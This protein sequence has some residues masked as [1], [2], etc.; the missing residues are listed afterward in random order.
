MDESGNIIGEAKAVSDI[1]IETTNENN[2]SDEDIHSFQKS[3]TA[4]LE[5]TNLNEYWINKLIKKK[6]R[7]KKNFNNK[8]NKFI[9]KENYHG[10]N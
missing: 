7:R 9:N 4:T 5:V 6:N 2:N 1:V 3:W 8:Y 10:R